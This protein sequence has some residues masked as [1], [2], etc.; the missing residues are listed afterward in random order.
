VKNI[1]GE[2]NYLELKNTEGYA[3]AVKQFDREVKPAFIG[4]PDQSWNIN[5][6]MTNLVDD[7]GNN[8]MRNCLRLKKYVFF[9]ALSLLLFR[10]HADT[11]Y[12]DAVQ[13]I[14]EP[15]ITAICQLVAEQVANIRIKRM[16]ANRPKGKEIKVLF[17]LSGASLC[18][19]INHIR[20]QAIFL[21]GE[22][23]SSQ[24]LKIRLEQANTDIQVIQPPDA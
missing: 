15:L 5:F 21:V 1:V 10:N 3:D 12:S 11:K 13:Q 14:F 9:C 16:T 18:F 20:T 2:I 17:K 7:P 4:D 24:Y 19:S 6:T 8:V 22:F 23:G